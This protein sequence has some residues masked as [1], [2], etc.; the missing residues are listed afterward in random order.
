MSSLYEKIFR[1][2]LFPLYEG[3]IRGRHTHRYLDEY[4]KSQWLDPAALEQLQIAK[5]NALLA[6]GWSNIPFLKRYWTEAGLDSRP[7]QHSSEIAQYPLITKQIITD[8]FDEMRA[9]PF[10]GVVLQ[11]TTGGSTGDPFKFEYSQESYARRTAVMWRGY[12]WCG[13]DLGRRTAYVWG[14][15]DPQPGFTGLKDRWYHA[16]FNRIMLNAFAMTEDN[17]ADYVAKIQKFRPEVIVGYVAPLLI[18]SRWMLENGVQ[19]NPPAAVISGA[20]ALARPDRET[21]AAAFGAPVFNTYGCREFMLLASEC[22]HQD[23]MHTSADH[24]IVETVNDDGQPVVGEIGDVCV[25]DLHNYAMPFV[26]YLNGDRA[27]SAE[28]KCNCGRG[29]PLLESID[30]RILD[31]IVTPDGRTVPGEFFVYVMLHHPTIKQYQVV[32]TSASRIEVRIVPSADEPFFGHED[33]VREIVAKMG[34][35]VEIEIC[36]VSDIPATASGKR[37][38][39]VSNIQ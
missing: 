33:M 13:S 24:L 7:L 2:V 17:H 10:D 9:S 29:L 21:I 26:R 18:L 39:T 12:R 16:A 3:P 32:Q 6:H 38:I 23:G 30:G 35:E 34:D 31:I 25:T 5:L 36:E 19:I 27:T 20:E 8:N 37:R 28:R 22:E 11:K 14:M 4:E 15:P 1:N